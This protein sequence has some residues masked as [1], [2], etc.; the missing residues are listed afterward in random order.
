MLVTGSDHG[1]LRI[2]NIANIRKPVLLR[3]IKL[4][5]NKPITNIAFNPQHNTIAVCSTD[6]PKVFFLASQTQTLI[7]YVELPVLC[8][9]IAWNTSTKQVIG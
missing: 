9:A 6:S 5:T 2:Y 4:F 7:G 1:V 3:L 8:N